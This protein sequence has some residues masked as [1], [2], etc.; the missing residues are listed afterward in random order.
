MTHKPRIWLVLY[1]HWFVIGVGLVFGLF[2]LPLLSAGSAHASTI[3][4]PA[5]GMRV[6]GNKPMSSLVPPAKAAARPCGGLRAGG[7]RATEI[8]ATRLTC[9]S[10]RRKLRRWLNRHRLP[11]NPF[12]WNC[13]R[14]RGR[15][16]CAVGQGNA[17]RFTFRLRRA[18]TAATVTSAGSDERA[19]G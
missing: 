10:A 17:P 2:F 13:F 5:D 11:R 12:G 16:M 4:T 14:W 7:R 15:W 1:R 18:A 6:E 19:I 8:N 3:H 9:A